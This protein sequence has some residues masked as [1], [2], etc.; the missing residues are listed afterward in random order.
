MSKWT[1]LSKDETKEILDNMI[2]EQ[3]GNEDYVPVKEEDRDK[4]IGKTIYSL[5]KKDETVKG[6][7]ESST[8]V[9]K[10]LKH[11]FLT[12]IL[13]KFLKKYEPRLIDSLPD[14]YHFDKLNRFNRAYLKTLDDWSY[15]YQSI[16]NSELKTKN[17]CDELFKDNS[18]GRLNIMRKAYLTV[19]SQ[20]SAYLEFHNM[21]MMNLKK[22]LAD[23][24]MNHLL[25]I[26]NTIHDPKYFIS[27]TDPA[28]WTPEIQQ[29]AKAL[30]DNNIRCA[31]MI[32][33]PDGTVY[34]KILTDSMP[35]FVKN[36]DMP[37][38]S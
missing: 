8:F 14:E 26:D 24:D 17:E 31:E 13:D 4:V 2:E 9:H 22:E 5:N 23:M 34:Y 28:K 25:Y 10:I 7:S 32:K 11:S 16:N 27:L 15:R 20:D 6:F 3:E 38:E 37:K 18:E 36:T 21:M 33:N 19:C 29:L 1:W 30:V 35:S 12:V